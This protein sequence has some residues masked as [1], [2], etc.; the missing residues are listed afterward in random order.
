MKKVHKRCTENEQGDT[1]PFS[2]N[3]I[4]QDK[5]R[6]GKTRQDKTRQ[7]KTRQDKDKTRQ[8]KDKTRLDK[9]RQ[10][11]DKTRTRHLIIVIRSVTI[12][13]SVIN[14]SSVMLSLVS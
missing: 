11:K 4:G 7:D 12:M 14:V 13:S 1:H 6:Q 10:D 2:Q 5:A 3:M 8:D 9:A